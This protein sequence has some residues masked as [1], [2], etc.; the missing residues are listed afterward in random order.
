MEFL[1][2]SVLKFGDYESKFEILY[3]IFIIL[4][5]IFFWRQQYIYIRRR[6]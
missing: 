1:H 6:A 2:G 3:A 4:I 5:N